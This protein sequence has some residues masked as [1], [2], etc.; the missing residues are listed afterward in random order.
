MDTQEAFEADGL[1]QLGPQW[2]KQ[3]ALCFLTA[4]SAFSAL[5][6]KTA[7]VPCSVFLAWQDNQP[8][9]RSPPKWC[10]RL[11]PKELRRLPG[12]SHVSAS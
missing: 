9:P 1:N 4:H 7:P 10:K 6:A 5:L 2:E 11:L 12:W 8:F 3:W